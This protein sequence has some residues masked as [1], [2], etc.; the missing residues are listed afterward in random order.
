MLEVIQ[1]ET[2]VDLSPEEWDA[3]AVHP[4][5]SFGWLR[6]LEQCTPQGHR[7]L[8][9][10][11]RDEQGIG[12]AFQCSVYSA[13][14]SSV[15]RLVYGAATPIAR[16]V[17]LRISPAISVQKRILRAGLPADQQ[18][19]HLTCLLDAIEKCAAERGCRICFEQVIHRESGGIGRAIPNSTDASINRS[20]DDS[21]TVLEELLVERGLFWGTDIPIAYLGMSPAWSQF[22]DYRR[23]LTRQHPK[24]AKHIKL[25]LN[26]QT[27]HGLT[28][29]EVDDPSQHSRFFALLE[30]HYR[31]L[32]RTGLRYGPDWLD[33]LRANL[34]DR[35]R[36][37]A[38]WRQDQLAG[39]S[40]GILHGGRL[41]YP[42]IGVDHQLG[43]PADA[44]SN[45]GYNHSVTTAISLGVRRVYFGTLAYSIKLRRGCALQ[46]TRFYVAMPGR[47]ERLL[48][49]PLMAVRQARLERKFGAAVM[50]PDADR[51]GL[52]PAA[53]PDGLERVH[54]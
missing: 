33:L 30:S 54:G 44:Y 24:T 31:R 10:A 41:A 1:T 17:G 2:I 28:I 45:L 42:Q 49:Q 48:F 19:R 38:A 39:V 18:R 51:P 12:A 26:R 6:T 27:R 32:N 34:G 9:L 8:Y 21:E 14:V 4:L 11:T 7:F 22:G 46:H 50:N 36:L 15:D 5:S 47:A 20:I 35:F 16:A 3:V 23:D 52:P 37:R 25:E 53:A 13:K 29:H 43:R 40:V